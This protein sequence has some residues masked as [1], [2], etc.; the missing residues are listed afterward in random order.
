[1]VPAILIALHGAREPEAAAVGGLFRFSKEWLAVA[2]SP[3]AQVARFRIPLEFDRDQIAA[4]R[5]VRY[6]GRM[7]DRPPPARSCERCGA[8]MTLVRVTPG[9]ARL[10]ELRTFRCEAC[11][12]IE[13]VERGDD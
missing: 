5:S 2:A 10:R 12:H 9:I 3:H 4:A 13:T 1:V 8:E 6:R 11:G 7:V